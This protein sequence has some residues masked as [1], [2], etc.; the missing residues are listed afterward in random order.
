MKFPIVVAVTGASGAIYAR[1]LLEVLVSTGQ[2]VHLTIS[3]SG[4]KVIK[5]ELDIDIDL[6]SFQIESLLGEVQASSTGATPGMVHYHHYQNM[7]SAIA[8]GSSRT[9]GMI[10]CPCSCGTLSAVVH[11]SS[12]NLIHR[13]ADVHLKEQRKLIVVPRETP[14]SI[15]HLE[16]MKRAAEAGAVV[17]PASPGWYHSVRDVSDLVDFVIARILDQLDI[18][19]SLTKRWGDDP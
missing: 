19:H 17:L 8:S 5:Q 18:E 1:R 15:V 7:L 6:G 11:G 12:T 13:A 10:I 9:A 14:L 2:D 16:N 4:R 3:T